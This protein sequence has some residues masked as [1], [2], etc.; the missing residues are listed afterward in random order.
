MTGRRSSH[1]MRKPLRFP[2]PL[3]AIFCYISLCAAVVVEA[4]PSDLI[5]SE[6]PP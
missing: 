2:L 4:Q 3:A 1:A 6:T 5:V